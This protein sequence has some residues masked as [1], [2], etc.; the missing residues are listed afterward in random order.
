MFPTVEINFTIFLFLVMSF[1]FYSRT[2]Q[3]IKTLEKQLDAK[4][5]EVQEVFLIYNLK[6]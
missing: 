5:T 1:A 6:F 3:M 2:V 4:F